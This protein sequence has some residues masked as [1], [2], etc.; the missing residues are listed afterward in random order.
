MVLPIIMKIRFV[1]IQD[2]P[3]ILIKFLMSN[4]L[5]KAK[6]EIILTKCCANN[7]FQAIKHCNWPIETH[8]FRA[9]ISIL[10]EFFYQDLLQISRK[11]FSTRQEINFYWTKMKLETVWPSIIHWASHDLNTNYKNYWIFH[12][13]GF[14]IH[15]KKMTP[16]KIKLVVLTIKHLFTIEFPTSYWF[17]NSFSFLAENIFSLIWSESW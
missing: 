1:D 2:D 15:R 5:L 16:L 17:G 4:S 10:R 9:S 8:Y 7:S 11:I 6:Q 13:F 12:E 14:I 3:P